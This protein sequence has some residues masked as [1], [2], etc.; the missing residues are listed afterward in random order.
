MPFDDLFVRELPDDSLEGLRTITE[1]FEAFNARHRVRAGHSA[2]GDFAGYLQAYALLNAY[3]Q[4]HHLDV[5]INIPVESSK[6]AWLEAIRRAFNNAERYLASGARE[7]FERSTQRYKK[8]LSARKPYV[9]D[10]PGFAHAQQLVNEMREAIASNAAL[11]HDARLAILGRLEGLAA[12]I[13]SRLSDLGHVWSLVFDLYAVAAGLGPHGSELAGCAR[14]LAQVFWRVRC[15]AE[16]IAPEGV[17]PLPLSDRADGPPQIG[18]RTQDR[19][20]A[21]SGASSRS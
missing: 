11:A 17:P 15:V 20:T 10:E 19:G 9:L 2:K 3:L 1:R 14:E 16:G 12:A 8:T 13:H 4:T 7:M 21:R 6:D 18:T 5:E